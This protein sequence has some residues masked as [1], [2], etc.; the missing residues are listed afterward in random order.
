MFSI[1]RIVGSCADV[2]CKHNL[3]LSSLPG[4]PFATI[5]VW[6]LKIP[7][8]FASQGCF[9]RTSEIVTPDMKNH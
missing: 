5:P 1:V 4:F 8:L 9:N 3:M 6:F 7:A 2:A